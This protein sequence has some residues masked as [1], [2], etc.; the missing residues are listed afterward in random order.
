[1]KDAIARGDD[2]HKK[3]VEEISDIVTFG[4]LN[5]MIEEKGT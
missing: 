1:L 2:Q 5:R 4:V 3:F